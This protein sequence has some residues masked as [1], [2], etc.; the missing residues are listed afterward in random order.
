M[1]GDGERLVRPV[2]IRP[3]EIPESRVVVVVGGCRRA[4]A[5]CV[6]HRNSAIRAAGSSHRNRRRVGA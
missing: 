2:S 1:H 5:G 3:V 4:V 6:M